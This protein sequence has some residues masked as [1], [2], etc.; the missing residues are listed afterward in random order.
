M[1]QYNPWTENQMVDAVNKTPKQ[2]AALD[3]LADAAD[4]YVKQERWS[5]RWTNALKAMVVIYILVSI[6]LLAG[7]LKSDDNKISTT[8][9]A[10]VIKINGAIMAGGRTS[11]EAI[12]PL[13][14]EAFETKSAKAVVLYMNSPGGSPVQSALIND[15]ITRLKHLHNK[16]I[17]VVAEDICASGCYYIAAAADKIFA[18]KG[19]IVGSIGVRFDSFGFTE[20]MDKIGV[21]NRSMTAGEYKS[22]INPFGKEDAEAKKFFQERILERTHQQFIEVVRAG[23][24]DRLNE[25]EGVFSGLVWLGDEAVEIGLIDG[26]GDLGSVVRDEIGLTRIRKYEQQ[27][28]LIEHIMGDLVSETALRLSQSLIGMK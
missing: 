20:L 19:S 10:A 12:N 1:E 23:R 2:P 27:K 18:N 6:I 7:F 26:L 28:S 3:R 22:F 13:L 11:A 24:G 9:H 5:R 16:P 25:V 21:E 15:E 14:R 17:Y 4:A 8:Q